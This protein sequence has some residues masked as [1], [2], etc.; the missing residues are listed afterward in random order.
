VG[1]FYTSITLRNA[2]LDSVVREM[3]ALHRESYVYSNGTLSTVYDREAEKQE[4]SILAALAEHLAGRLRTTAF[5]VLNHD[6]DVLWF[7]LYDGDRLVAEYC[8][9]QRPVTD[10]AGLAESLTGGRSRLQL[11]Y[12]LRRPYL[13]QIDRHIALNKLFGFPEASILGYGYIHRGERSDDMAGGQ[14]VHV[15]ATD[16]S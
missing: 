12:L 1:N 7:Q 10:I 2:P 13:F 9:Q 4:T 5:A 16:V 6:D 3:R 15:P 14:L 11:R 8:N